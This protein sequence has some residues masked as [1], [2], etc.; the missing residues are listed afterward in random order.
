VVCVLEQCGITSYRTKNLWKREKRRPS[1]LE[2]NFNQFQGGQGLLKVQ[3]REAALI[4][5]EGKRKGSLKLTARPRKHWGIEKKEHGKTSVLPPSAPH[6]RLQHRRRGKER[7]GA[8]KGKE[9]TWGESF[10]AKGR[11]G[12]LRF[13]GRQRRNQSSTESHVNPGCLAKGKLAF[14][15]AKGYFGKPVQLTGEKKTCRVGSVQNG[16]VPDTSRI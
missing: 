13:R 5:L 2:P 4:R 6:H 11:K 1:K 9:K 10:R 12:S 8:W 16:Q 7:L 15:N 14:R 3:E